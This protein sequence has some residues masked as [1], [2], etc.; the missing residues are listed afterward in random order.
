M[1]CAVRRTQHTRTTRDRART[2]RPS[3]GGDVIDVLQYM[4]KYGLP[5]ESCLH[6]AATDH[7]A[8]KEHGMERCPADKF[9]V[10]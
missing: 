9:C 4:S 2:R 6:Y 7:S 1:P 10:K 8:F 3:P 5:D